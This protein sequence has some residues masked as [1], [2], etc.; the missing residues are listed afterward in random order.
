MAYLAGPAPIISAVTKVSLST[1]FSPNSISQAA[2]LE[3]LRGPKAEIEAQ[4][5]EYRVRRDL[6]VNEIQAIPSLPFTVP[7][8]TFFL[9]ANCEAYLGLTA[10]NG[11]RIET[12]LDLVLHI[13]RESAVA[14]M[15]GSGFGMPGH[16]RIS[17]ATSEQTL[18]D[19]VKR[20]AGVL[21]NLRPKE[22]RTA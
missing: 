1:A 21:Q 2:T 5:D 12:D 4:V 20:L 11:Q 7:C 16:I 13:L 17:F 3:A 9:F 10:P 18:R 14:L 8:G 15:P 19:A 22:Q 6:L